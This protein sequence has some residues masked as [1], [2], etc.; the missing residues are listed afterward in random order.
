MKKIVIML[1]SLL[2]MML[3][4]QVENNV[5]NNIIDSDFDDMMKVLEAEMTF[6]EEDAFVLRFADAETDEPVKDAIIDIQGIGSYI[7]D[8]QGLI[9]FPKQKDGKYNFSFKKDGYIPSD[10]T[11]EVIA[12]MIYFNRFSVSKMMELGHIRIVLDWGSSPNDLDIHLE[13]VGK[14][15]ISYHH[16]R[17]ADDGSA[18]LDR[19]D[20]DGQGP[21][22]ITITDVDDNASYTC[23]VH[24][25]T[26]RSNTSSNKLSKSK[27]RITVYN[28]NQVAFIINVPTNVDGT[29]WNVFNLDK[30]VFSQTNNVAN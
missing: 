30:G 25:Y 13:K 27:G 14:Y 7:T 3:F 5:E 2:P 20:I 12:Q 28:N 22:T 8:G 6:L 11:F 15:H 16:K 29:R 23:Y 9:K 18:K 4:S 21:E 24:D 26:N 1:M 10:F 19:D 17:V